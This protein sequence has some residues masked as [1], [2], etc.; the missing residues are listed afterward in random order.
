LNF[1]FK[2]S[3]LKSI[4][5][6]KFRLERYPLHQEVL[7]ADRGTLAE[8][9]G[10]SRQCIAYSDFFFFFFSIVPM[11][12]IARDRYLVLGSHDTDELQLERQTR[13]AVQTQTF[14]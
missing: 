11:L 14:R 2:V 4:L 1:S 7:F 13:E 12:L 6:N 3:S 8:N 10:F 5:P 9:N